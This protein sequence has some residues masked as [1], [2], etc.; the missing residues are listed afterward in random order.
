MSSHVQLIAIIF[1]FIPSWYLLSDL[2]ERKLTLAVTRER[3]TNNKDIF[4]LGYNVYNKTSYT[5][6][7]SLSIA[8]F[9]FFIYIYVNL[10]A[11]SP[12]WTSTTCWST[13]S[14]TWRISCRCMSCPQ[15]STSGTCRW[16]SAPWADWAARRNTPNSSTSSPP[17]LPQVILSLCQVFSDLLN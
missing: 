17:S 1:G 10:Q 9:F 14:M 15:A 13:I 5:M 4:S 6:S 3:K 7:Y 8:S 2:A 12:V 11:L 16:T